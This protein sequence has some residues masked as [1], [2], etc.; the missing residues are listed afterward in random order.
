MGIF[1]KNGSDNHLYVR[2]M[3]LEYGNGPT[4]IIITT[5]DGGSFIPLCPNTEVHTI[6]LGPNILLTPHNGLLNDKTN[7]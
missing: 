3:V 7:L 4:S 2:G 6:T 1:M 5:I